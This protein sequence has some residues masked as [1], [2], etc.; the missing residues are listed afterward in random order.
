MLPS[1]RRCSVVVVKV[2]N[3]FKNYLSQSKDRRIQAL[4]GLSFE[5]VK[6]EILGI[7]GESGCGKSTLARLISGLESPDSGSVSI[8][9]ELLQTIP[10]LN[11][12]DQRRA[13]QLVFQDP[14]S[15]LNPRQT[16]YQALGEV[17]TVYEPTLS[18]A[19]TNNRIHE[20][21]LQVGISEDLANRYPHQFS[22]GQRQRICIARSLAARPEILILDEPVS[23]L[24][25]SVR[26]E[27]INLLLDLKVKMNLTYIF[28]SH[29]LEIVKHISD[30]ILVMNDGEIVESGS[31][32]EIM[33]TPKAEYTKSLIAAIPKINRFLNSKQRGD[34]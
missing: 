3:V 27:I 11:F 34:S 15:S 10:L 9:G 26:A 13:V 25:V 23:A 16:V 17:L 24:D 18:S 19:Q 28:V 29:D 1:R 8:Q 22:G 31:W 33:N 4:N 7:V 12:R 6:G 32:S 20:L 2:E 30:K 21:L 5:L 14:Y